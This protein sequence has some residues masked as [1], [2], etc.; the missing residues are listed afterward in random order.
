MAPKTIQIIGSLNIDLITRTPRHPSPG[1]T[2]TATS[3]TYGPGG[4]GANQAVACARLSRSKNQQQQA[5]SSSSSSFTPTSDI[6]IEMIGAVGTD[7][8]GNY[9]LDELKASGVDVA[10]V[11]E[12]EGE[13]TGT[14][15]VIVEEKS[16]ENRI[17]ITPGGNASVS[18]QSIQSSL[19]SLP[20]L[21]I[22][23]LEIPIPTVTAI[24]ETAKQKGVD[25][26]LNPAPAVENLPRSVYKGLKHLIMNE[27]E[28]SMLSK[29]LGDGEEEGEE[30]KRGDRSTPK[31]MQDLCERFHA[32]GVTNVVITLGSNG[33]YYSIRK[34]AEGWG[35]GG[36]MPAAKVE[37]VVDTTAAGD[38]FVGAYAVA[39]VVHGAS[40][41]DAVRWANKAGARTVEKE[42]AQGAIPWGDEVGGM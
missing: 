10:S 42:G 23:Q 5:S 12:V 19:E 25:V 26:L 13:R 34:D 28:A 37:K 36:H 31:N 39:I 27:T 18:P 32:L 6:N 14:A 21:I 38:T 3:F 17:L 35:E 16:G 40:V 22:L 20:D 2:L 15:V 9:L 30:E 33:V 1:E 4:K 24:I 8:F 7:F 11:R 41:P 29:F